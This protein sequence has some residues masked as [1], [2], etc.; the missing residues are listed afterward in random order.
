M[1]NRPIYDDA[2][3]GH[4][5]IEMRALPAGPTALDMVANAAFLIGLAEGVRPQINELMPGL[6]FPMAEYNFYR[7]AQHGLQAKL[8]W[9]SLQQ[10]GCAEHSVTTLVEA[11]LPLA[12]D[13]L[14]SI[15]ISAQEASRYL[16]ILEA[17]LIVGRNG[18]DWQLAMLAQLESKLPRREALQAM[19]EK[20]MVYSAENRPV[21]EWPL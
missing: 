4:L 12:R 14:L 15:G 3:G 2:D 6:P 8:L 9:P 1:W 10:S 19:L 18:A 21:A 7:A 16:G 5:R 11:L 20:Y 17:R 13:G